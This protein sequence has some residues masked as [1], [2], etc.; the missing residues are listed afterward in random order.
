MKGLVYI[1][2]LCSLLFSCRKDVVKVETNVLEYSFFV[3]GHSY[4]NPN[5]YSGGLHPPFVAKFNELNNDTLIKMGFLNGDIV[6]YSTPTYW[7]LVDADVEKLNCPVYMVAG[8]HDVTDMDLYTNRYGNTYYDF[9]FNNDLFIVLDGNMDG[10][11]IS[12]A[13]LEFLTNVLEKI[14]N[15]VKNIFILSHQLI[16]SDRFDHLYNSNE[17]KADELNF[18]TEILPKLEKLKQKVFLIAGDVGAYSYSNSI[19]YRRE[20]NIHYMASGMGSGVRENILI[21]DCY[22]NGTVKIRVCGLDADQSSDLGYIED[23]E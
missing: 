2:V 13:Q 6:K 15:S 10:W 16:F 4:G 18:V 12:G 11:R 17:G 7:D 14:D 19:F 23:Y 3:A 8:N 20:R 1:L 22:R 5:Q 9:V 21:F